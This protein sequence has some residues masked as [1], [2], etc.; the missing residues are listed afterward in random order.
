MRYFIVVLICISLMTS[1]G[2]HL[3]LCLLAISMSSLEKKSIQAFCPFLNWVVCLF[4]V[5]LYELFIYFGY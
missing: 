1:N 3:F 5:E 2:E 4:D